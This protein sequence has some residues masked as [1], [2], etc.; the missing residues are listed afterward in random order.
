[1]YAIFSIFTS[2]TALSRIANA[3]SFALT[4]WYS[5]SFFKV[6]FY[7]SKM[8]HTMEFTPFRCTVTCIL[9]NACNNVT[10]TISRHRKFLSLRKVPCV[11]LRSVSFPISVPVKLTF[12]PYSFAFPECHINGNMQSVAFSIFLIS[13]M[14]LK[15]LHM[16]GYI[17]SFFLSIA[18]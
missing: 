6:R 4:N 7:K 15:L 11:T 16:A 5:Q 17:S 13:I 1:M 18:E 2:G 14:H 10:P 8:C 12:C 3:L 9:K